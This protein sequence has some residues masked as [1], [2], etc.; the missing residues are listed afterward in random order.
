MKTTR[1]KYKGFIIDRDALGWLYI[2][3]THSPYTE[4]SDRNYIGENTIKAAKEIIN[5]LLTVKENRNG[6]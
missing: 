5:W 4:D 1:R 6:I 3:D 2:Y